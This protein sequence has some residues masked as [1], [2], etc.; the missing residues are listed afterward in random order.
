MVMVDET[1]TKELL[2]FLHYVLLNTIMDIFRSEHGSGKS[3]KCTK[4]KV[5]CASTNLTEMS[6]CA[7]GTEKNIYDTYV[8]ETIPI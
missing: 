1:L 6:R 7:K 2:I 3:L 5:C 8:S 4:F